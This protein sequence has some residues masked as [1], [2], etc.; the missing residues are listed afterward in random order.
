LHGGGILIPKRVRLDCESDTAALPDA[1]TRDQCGGENLAQGG[2]PCSEIDFR[3]S[4]LETW[5]VP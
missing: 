4:A 5:G 3:V 2:W 1:A